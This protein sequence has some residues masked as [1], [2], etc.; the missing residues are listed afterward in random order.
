ME[1]AMQK[2]LTL[3]FLTS[4]TL[5]ALDI[6]SATQEQLKAIKGIG[7]KK[8]SAILAYRKANKCFETVDELQK[9]KGI[10]AK[11]L[12]KHKSELEAKNCKR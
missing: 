5:F 4:F 8:A 6:N 11:F 10:G 7:E 9:V 3:T 1:K 2:L 12:Q